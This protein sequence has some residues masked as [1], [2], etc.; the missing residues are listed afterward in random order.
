MRLL[1]TGLFLFLGYFLIC[2]LVERL[3]LIELWPGGLLP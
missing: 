3:T 1:V 2:L